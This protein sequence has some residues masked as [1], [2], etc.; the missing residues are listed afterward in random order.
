MKNII[1]F[2]PLALSAALASGCSTTDTAWTQ[3]IRQAV[4]EPVKWE[5]TDILK[6]DKVQA[7]FYDGLPYKGKPT[8]IFAWYGMP[9]GASP[10]KKVPAVVLVHGGGATAL[11]DWVQLWNSKGYAAI[12]M[13]CCGG[14]PAGEGNPYY[15]EI[16]PRHE[17]SGPAGWGKM[18]ESLLPVQ[19]QWMFHAVYAALRSKDILKMFPEVDTEKIGITG[20]SWGGVLTIIC[21]GIDDSFRFS[22]PVYGCGFFNTPQSTLLYRGG[23]DREIEKWFS[24]F[25]PGHFLTG[26][27][28]PVLFFTDAEDV[29]FP[30]DRWAA[31]TKTV[32]APK[33]L[34]LRINYPHDHLI[35]WKSNTIFDFADAALTGRQLPEISTPSL[36]NN[37]LSAKINMFER[38]AVGAQL[39]YTRASGY[40]A[41]RRWQTINATIKD[42]TVSAV[43]PAGTTAAYFNIRDNKNSLWSSELIELNN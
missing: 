24:L 13:D 12:A 11:A 8:R 7:I 26:I 27:K 4:S 22:I 25:D 15:R 39:H 17:F 3:E 5:K 19:D 34:S 2:V 1:K 42:G 33:R 38:K 21:S 40:Y 36:E 9:D 43:L 35:C 37:V 16:W 6:A 32:N 10:D 29:S 18:E 14:I 41:D 30:L 28:M 31:S 23:N 20:I